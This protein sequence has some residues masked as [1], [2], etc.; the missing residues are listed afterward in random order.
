MLYIAKFAKELKLDSISFQKLR[1]E[2]FSPLKEVVES[3]PGYH[4]TRIGGAVYSDRYGLKEL[5]LIRNRI[6]SGFYDIPQIIRIAKKARRIGLFR[7]R[8]LIVALPNLPLLLWRLLKGKKLKKKGKT[9][10]PEPIL[11]V[12]DNI[13][14]L[15]HGT[16]SPQAHTPI[17][18]DG[19]N[20]S[21]SQKPN[22]V[23]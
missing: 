23:V 3:T 17:P 11:P 22:V 2:K 8:D 1:I 5:K 21:K 4:Y 16:D 6:R 18:I 13:S 12:V 10:G 15:G 20:Q 19:K 14:H 9:S 7:F